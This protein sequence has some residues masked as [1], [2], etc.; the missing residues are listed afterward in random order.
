VPSKQV[1]ANILPDT[2]LRAS[3]AFIIPAN[4][5]AIIAPAVIVPNTK[6][7][8]MLQLQLTEHG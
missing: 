4:A 7:A 8:S 1:N 3:S 2:N 6:R 5:G